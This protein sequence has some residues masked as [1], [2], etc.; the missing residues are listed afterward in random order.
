MR[1]ISSDRFAVKCVNHEEIRPEFHIITTDFKRGF[2]L[3]CALF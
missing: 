2:M 1:K 3:K